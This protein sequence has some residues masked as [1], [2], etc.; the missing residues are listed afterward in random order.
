MKRQ[1]AYLIARAQVPVE[2]TQSEEEEED[3]EG[4]PEDLLDCLNNTKLSEHFKLFGKELGVEEPKSL[5]DIYKTHL[6]HSR[7]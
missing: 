7:E 5:E 3:S 2:W 6:E 1:L 4:V